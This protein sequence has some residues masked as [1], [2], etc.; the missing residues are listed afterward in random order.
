ML[1]PGSSMHPDRKHGSATM[2]QEGF[3]VKLHASQ[4]FKYTNAREINKHTFISS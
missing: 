4:S 1:D 3:N 2:R